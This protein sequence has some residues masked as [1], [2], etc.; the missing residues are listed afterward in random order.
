MVVESIALLLGE[1]GAQ[2]D[3]KNQSI[4]LQEKYRDNPINFSAIS[5]FRNKA[6]HHY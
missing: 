6:Y 1:I 5:K 2:I 3:S 4:E